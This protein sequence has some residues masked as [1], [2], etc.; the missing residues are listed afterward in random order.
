MYL[1]KVL[2]DNKIDNV[3][4]RGQ[5]GQGWSEEVKARRVN[6]TAVWFSECNQKS[7][8]Y[9]EL[10][11]WVLERYPSENH[12]FKSHPEQLC[13]MVSQKKNTPKTFAQHV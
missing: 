10:Y 1:H 6:Q 9:I 4:D 13:E 8:K 3:N 5:R 12:K 2:R 11:P 7:L